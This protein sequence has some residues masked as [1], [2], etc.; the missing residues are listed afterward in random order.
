M[1]QTSPLFQVLFFLFCLLLAVV[2]LIQGLSQVSPCLHYLVSA[3]GTLWEWLVPDVQLHT[4]WKK[5][6]LKYIRNMDFITRKEFDAICV[7]FVL[8]VL[9]GLNTATAQQGKEMTN[10]N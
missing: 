10:S 5:S 6:R 1:G 2:S 7:H 3:A 8:G 9:F 4:I